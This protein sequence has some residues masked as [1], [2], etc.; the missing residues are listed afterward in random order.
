M[1]TSGPQEEPWDP[2]AVLRLLSVDRMAPYLQTCDDDLDRAFELYNWNI[3][4]ASALQGTCAMVEVVVRNSIDLAL[5]E[6]VEQQSSDA[7]WFDLAVLDSRAKVDISI[8]RQRATRSAKNEVTHGKVLAELSFGFWRFLTSKRYLTSLWTPVLHKAFPL[9]HQDIWT[10]QKQVSSALT[11]LTIVRNRAA[12]L[13]PVFRRDL[14]KDLAQA[15]LLMSWINPDATAWLLE[16]TTL[17]RVIET[18]PL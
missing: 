12:H 16:A 3:E 6:W 8:A 15:E 18:K 10:R 7:D 11:G 14:G 2:Y 5:T 1:S 4:A 9:G 13:E 17:N